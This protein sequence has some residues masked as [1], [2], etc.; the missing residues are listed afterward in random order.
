MGSVLD[1]IA[2]NYLRNPAEADLSEG[3]Q[4]LISSSFEDIEEGKFIDYHMHVLGL[5]TNNS[6]IWLSDDLFSF[7]HPADSLKTKA[8]INAAGIENKERADLEYLEQMITFVNLFPKKGKFCLL[9]LDRC[10]DKKGN[11]DEN[12]SKMY[13]P[14]DWLM[15]VCKTN[16]DKFIPCIS[17]NP[18]KKNAAEELEKWAAE[19]VRMVKWMPAVMGM[20]ASDELCEPFYAAMQKNDMV[21]LTHVGKEDNVPV[22]KFQPLNNPLLFRKPL[23]MGV[24]VIM[25]HCASSGTNKDIDNDGKPVDNYELF[26]RLMDEPQYKDL[27]FGDISAITQVNR[28]GK[29]LATA[30][31]RTDLHS[32]LLHGSDYPLPALNSLISTRLLVTS[33]YLDEEDREPLNEIYKANPLLFDYVLKRRLKHPKDDSKK[34]AASMFMINKNLGVPV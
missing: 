13:I 23:E 18:Y 5:G 1:Y 10:Y 21:L 8:Y 6:G 16:K 17:I 9:A 4:D 30:L 29:P 19:G 14:N 33:G 34:F 20:D 27:L 15:Q 11:L 2:G 25:A 32:R 3:A 12:N 7:L 24:K 26:F 22:T 28:M 31:E